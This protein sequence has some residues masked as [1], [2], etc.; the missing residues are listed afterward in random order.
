MN[1]V[2][3]EVKAITSKKKLIKLSATGGKGK[4]KSVKMSA[5]KIIKTLQTKC[6][7]VRTE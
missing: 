7:D 6:K 4:A 5:H 3:W 2:C 1:A